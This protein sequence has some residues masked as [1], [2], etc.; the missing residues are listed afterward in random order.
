MHCKCKI[1]SNS[2]RSTNICSWRKHGL[3]FV[4][5]LRF[6]NFNNNSL[7]L[8]NENECE[9]DANV[10]WMFMSGQLHCSVCYFEW[11]SWE[12]FNTRLWNLTTFLMEW[13]FLGLVFCDNVWNKDFRF[14]NFLF[15]H[16]VSHLWQSS[17]RCEKY[18]H[19]LIRPSPLS[20]WAIS[21][22]S[23]AWI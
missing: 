12:Y 18:S 19:F 2:P 22:L 15:L 14:Y 6:T 10:L 4:T 16:Q 7:T 21:L 9:D 11:W 13:Y 3:T 23:K 1:S 20:G 17:E 5:A 8:N